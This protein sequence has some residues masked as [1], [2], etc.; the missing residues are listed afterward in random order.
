MT[1]S[2][3]VITPSFNQGQFIERTI[4]SVLSQDIPDL[5]YTVIDGGSTDNTVDILKKYQTK[6]RWVS[7][8]DRG[9]AHA[10]NKGLQATHG[11]IIGWLNSDDIYYPH[12]LKSI[13]H[14]FEKHDNIDIIYGNAYHIDSNDNI[15]ETYYTETWDKELLKDVCFLCQPAVF[16]RRR[17]IDQF[18]MLNE[19]LHYCMDYEYWLRLALNNVKFYFVPHILAGSRLH[20]DTKTLGSRVKVHK[21]INDMM[22]L[23]LKYVPDRWLKNYGHAMAETT[24]YKNKLDFEKTVLAHTVLASVK[25]NKKITKDMLRSILGLSRKYFQKT[26]LGK[27]PS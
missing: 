6:L 8:K 23:H 22:K 11:D 7:E 1:L 16:F 12:A 3:S 19:K 26:F 2:I 24:T 15:L 14:I 5:E 10:V 17:L 21:E 20:A 4:Q 18:G 13:K 9:Q 25:W 27:Q